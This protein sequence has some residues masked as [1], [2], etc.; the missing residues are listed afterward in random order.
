LPVGQLD[1]GHISYALFGPFHRKISQ[2][3]LLFLIPLGIFYWPGWLLWSA[4]LLFL[5]LRHP[6][7]SDDSAPLSQR[8]I[9]LGWFALTMFVLCFTPIPFYIN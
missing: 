7:T 4:V 1:G 5:G 9:W 3:F 2:S 8:H 6:M